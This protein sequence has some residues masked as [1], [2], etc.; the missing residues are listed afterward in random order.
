MIPLW[1]FQVFRILMWYLHKDSGQWS[2]HRKQSRV[3][4]LLT[5]LRTSWSGSPGSLEVLGLKSLSTKQQPVSAPF[6]HNESKEKSY[7]NKNKVYKVLMKLQTFQIRVMQINVHFIIPGEC[8]RNGSLFYKDLMPFK[9]VVWSS[10]VWEGK[11]KSLMNTYIFKSTIIRS[12]DS[13]KK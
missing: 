2:S 7:I 5:G 6:N 12:I 4:L 11:Q 13:K 8:R 1:F 3:Q 10:T 9:S